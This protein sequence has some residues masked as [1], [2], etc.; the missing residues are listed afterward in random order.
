MRRLVDPLEAQKSIAER[1]QPLG[2]AMT[3]T[4]RVGG[5]VVGQ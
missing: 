1:Y 2:D 4:M 5:A 3:I